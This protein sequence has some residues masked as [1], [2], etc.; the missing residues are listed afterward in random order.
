MAFGGHGNFPGYMDLPA[1]VAVCDTGVDL[2]KDLV[3][4]AF[5]AKRLVLV[6]NQWGDNRVA[7]YAM[8]ELKPGKTVNDIAASKS[9]IP[10]DWAGGTT[11]GA[12]PASIGPVDPAAKPKDVR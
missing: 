2:Y 3:H 11:K 7:V 12:P 10:P 4:P 5:E 1:G 8:G 6:T 9:V